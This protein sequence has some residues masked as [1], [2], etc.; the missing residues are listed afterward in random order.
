MTSSPW[1]IVT[2]SSAQFGDDFST[3]ALISCS[4]RQFAG[5]PPTFYFT[6]FRQP[7]HCWALASRLFILCLAAGLSHEV[8]IS[9]DHILADRLAHIVHGEE[10]DGGSHEGFHLDPRLSSAL[11]PE[12][13]GQMGQTVGQEKK[14]PGDKMGQERLSTAVSMAAL[15]F[16]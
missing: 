8:N 4:G 16:H 10:G 6:S 1:G 3:A 5:Y 13:G 7:V 9:D 12:M 14:F 11:Y 15:L 2:A